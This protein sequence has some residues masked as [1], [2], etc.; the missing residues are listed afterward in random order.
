MAHP[1]LLNSVLSVPARPFCCLPPSLPAYIMKLL[2]QHPSTSPLLSR[3]TRALPSTTSDVLTDGSCVKCA[4]DIGTTSNVLQTVAIAKMDVDGE[5]RWSEKS[6]FLTCKIY[7]LY[8]FS[9]NPANISKVNSSKNSSRRC[10]CL[11]LPN[12]FASRPSKAKRH[13]CNVVRK[14][15][16]TL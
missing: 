7:S 12:I 9:L 16:K 10:A 6:E 5:W 15:I 3:C 11:G 4:D 13:N 14:K 2:P 1:L 8:F